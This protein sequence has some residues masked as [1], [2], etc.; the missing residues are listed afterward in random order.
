MPIKITSIILVICILSMNLELC[1]EYFKNLGPAYRKRIQIP[2]Q[3]TIQILKRHVKRI[4]KESESFTRNY[5]RY[6]DLKT[7]ADI[8]RIDH[9]FQ[10]Y[11]VLGKNVTKCQQGLATN[12]SEISDKL[13]FNVMTCLNHEKKMA[14]RSLGIVLNRT[15]SE[16]RRAYEVMQKYHEC[17]HLHGDEQVQCVKM[18][19][20][21]VHLV[22]LNTPKDI[23]NLCGLKEKLSNYV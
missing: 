12:I 20:I 23:N 11:K 21:N 10:K 6:L 17:R 5:R 18:T 22:Y 4:L 2:F 16:R 19:I 3:T 7:K 8:A 13:Y 14:Q 1:D 9:I 15:R